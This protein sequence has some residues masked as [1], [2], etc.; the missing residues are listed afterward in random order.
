MVSVFHK[1]TEPHLSAVLVLV[2][3]LDLDQDLPVCLAP[4]VL[5]VDQVFPKGTEL[6]PLDSVVLPVLDLELLLVLDSVDP[7]VLD[8]ELPPVPV[9]VVPPVLVLELLPVLDLEAALEYPNNT[10]S[11]VS[12]TVL[13]LLLTQ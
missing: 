8:L 9:S 7:P 5:V 10:V 3:D 6:H 12:E 1:D 4:L 13:V 11:Q 2:S